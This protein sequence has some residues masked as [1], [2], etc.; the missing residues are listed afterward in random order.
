[1]WLWSENSG[2][3]SANEL[4]RQFHKKL[5]DS[6]QDLLLADPGPRDMFDDRVY[7]RGAI[8]LHTLRRVIGDTK[9][10]TLLPAW[11]DQ[12]RYG[13]VVTEACTGLAAEFADASLRPLWDA[14]LYSPKVPPLNNGA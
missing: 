6:P 7:K 3:P 10:F 14:W 8:T 13:T 12:N 2:G 1:E 9:F 11:T 4:A 5:M